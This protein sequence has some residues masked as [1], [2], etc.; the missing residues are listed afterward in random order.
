M[1]TTDDDLPLLEYIN[2]NHLL[3]RR[4]STTT[5]GHTVEYKYMRIALYRS[6]EAD[7]RSNVDRFKLSSGAG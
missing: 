4:H 6:I 7:I 5:A 3:V 1:K 2:N